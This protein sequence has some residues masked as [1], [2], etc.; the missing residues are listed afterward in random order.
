MIRS[1][2]LFVVGVIGASH[3]AVAAPVDQSQFTNFESFTPNTS[4]GDDL[5]IGITPETA[6]FTGE[7]QFAGFAGI[8]ELYNSGIRAWMLPAGSTAEIRFDELNAAVVEFYARTRSTAN[9]STLITALA[10]DDSVID[11]VVLSAGDPFQLVSF[12]GDINR[13]TLANQASGDSNQM[14]IDDFGFTAVPEPTTLAIALSGAAAFLAR[15]R[16]TA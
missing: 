9:G 14:A 15:R 12:N 5:V 11:S 13:I 6:T 3:V 7:D 1:V 4:P 16:R 10:D 8:G 2:L